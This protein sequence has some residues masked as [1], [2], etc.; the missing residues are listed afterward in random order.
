[1]DW[2]SECIIWNIF[3]LNISQNMHS[4]SLL[5]INTWCVLVNITAV[6][7]LSF[8]PPY[9]KISSLDACAPQNLT[10]NSALL[11]L[12]LPVLRLTTP[13][14]D[15]A[16][17]T[18]LLC[19]H[20]SVPREMHTTGDVGMNKDPFTSKYMVLDKVG[21]S[22]FSNTVWGGNGLLPLFPIPGESS[23]IH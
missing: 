17:C 11:T 20:T 9:W 23:Y 8:K 18:K 19:A 16:T 3:E 7:P 14:T 12:C 13:T 10:H 22:N 2:S 6:Q 15:N 21:T 1:V 5:V 4:Q